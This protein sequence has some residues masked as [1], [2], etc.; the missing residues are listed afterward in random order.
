MRAERMIFQPVFSDDDSFEI[1][2]GYKDYY[3]IVEGQNFIYD[4]QPV[5]VKNTDDYPELSGEQQP[6]SES[7]KEA[8]AV[9]ETSGG[10][11]AETEAESAVAEES[12]A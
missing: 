6:V 1:P 2:N 5:S 3:F 11:D 4:G 8:A 7:E 10:Q 12:A 9:Q